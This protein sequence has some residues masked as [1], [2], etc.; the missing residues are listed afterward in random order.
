MS[1]SSHRLHRGE[2]SVVIIKRDLGA[3]GVGVTS[4][5]LMLGTD[6]HRYVVKLMQNKVGPKVLASEWLG[7][8]LA[9]RIGLCVPRGEM[10]CI[11]P[12]LVEKSKGKNI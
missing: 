8:R 1:R 2:Q 4:P 11:P 9:R 5:R 3:V 7:F 10:V 12:A 6:G